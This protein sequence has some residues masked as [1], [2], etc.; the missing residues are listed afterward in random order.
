MKTM[1]IY[2]SNDANVVDWMRKMTTS[3]LDKR[4]KMTHLAE[5]MKVNYSMLYRFMNEKPVGQEFFIAWFKY[6][7]N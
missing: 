6:F 5:D 2:L 3:R 4:Y 7:V 1:T